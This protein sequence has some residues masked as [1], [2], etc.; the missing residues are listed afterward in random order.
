LRAGQLS[1]GRPGNAIV[2][3]IEVHNSQLLKARQIANTLCV[4]G[5]VLQFELEV[6][7]MI[8]LRSLVG[9]VLLASGCASTGMV[10]MDVDSVRAA[11]E[12]AAGPRPTV[13]V[14]A[15]RV[16]APKA[17]EE[18][19]DGLQDMLMMAL[20]RTGCCRV[21]EPA[22]D[23][24][25]GAEYL[26]TG[27]LTEFEPSVTGAKASVPADTPG[28]QL[29]GSF[30]GVMQRLG[31]DSA[32]TEAAQVGLDIRL[33]KA[34]E[35]RHAAHVTGYAVDIES[36]KFSDDSLGSGMEVYSNTPMEAAVRDAIEQAAQE[37]AGS[38]QPSY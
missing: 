25:A 4:T 12:P 34:G 20:L 6:L 2:F 29:R 36:L 3:E 16:A 24:G 10:G 21:L 35:I 28:D 8:L 1:I 15:F 31:L 5:Q 27:A 19:G 7:V 11:P 26:V 37:I 23:D 33:V 30:R 32:E 22:G 9:I 13:A 14:S 18:V 17:K 38:A